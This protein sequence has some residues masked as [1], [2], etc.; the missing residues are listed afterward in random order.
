MRWLAKS[1]KRG[2]YPSTA[3]PNI[4]E[5]MY[6]LVWVEQNNQYCAKSGF[7]HPV[8]VKNWVKKHLDADTEYVVAVTI[9]WYTYGMKFRRKVVLHVEVEAPTE[10]DVNDMIMDVYGSAADFGVVVD[11]ISI[12]ASRRKW[13]V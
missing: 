1:D 9:L 10:F 7:N 4:G 8:N 6:T 5:I 11:D 12:T 13:S 2:Q 3:P